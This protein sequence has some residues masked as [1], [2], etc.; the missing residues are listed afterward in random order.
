MWA[1]KGIEAPLTIENT[2]AHRRVYQSRAFRTQV[3]RIV[4]VLLWWHICGNIN[5]THM[6]NRLFK[7]G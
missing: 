7:H 3:P 1:D 6:V 4:A 2:L 5:L